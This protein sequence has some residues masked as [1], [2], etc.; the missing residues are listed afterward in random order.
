MFTT[1]QTV[2]EGLGRVPGKQTIK[3]NS[4]VI[5]VGKYWGR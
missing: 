1:Y 2:F 3:M 5:L 4:N